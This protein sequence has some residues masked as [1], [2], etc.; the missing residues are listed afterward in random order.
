MS[1]FF[2][3]LMTI[4]N[5]SQQGSVAQLSRVV[6]DLHQLA[7]R[8]GLDMAQMTALLN[9][10][11]KA[12]Q[13]VLQDQASALGTVGLESLLGKLSGA[14]SLGLLQVVIP[15]PLQREI[16]QTV[17][18]PTGVEADC[19][20]AMLPQL[21]PAILGLLGMGAVKPG[22]RGSNSLLE[23]FLQLPPGQGTDLGTVLALATRFLNPPAQV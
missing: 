19:I 17:A 22:T 18:Q 9:H 23:A 10:L 5:P 20:Q 11:G 13:P 2:D 4:N 1:L 8:Q 16:I 15:R 3:V 12:L 21:L 14:G 7:H 6:D